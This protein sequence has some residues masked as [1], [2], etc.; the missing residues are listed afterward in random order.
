MKDTTRCSIGLK[1]YIDLIYIK[2]FIIHFNLAFYP[3]TRV[4]IQRKVQLR[5]AQLLSE[6][7]RRLRSILF[8]QLRH[9][10]CIKYS[11]FASNSI[12]TETNKE[13]RTRTPCTH[14]A[15]QHNQQSYVSFLWSIL[16][17]LT[18]SS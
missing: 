13:C 5:V 15:C 2:I 3:Q 4:P 17:I 8:Q 18:A 10:Y 6:H 11:F 9:R 14:R 16:E 1:K 7:E 12:V